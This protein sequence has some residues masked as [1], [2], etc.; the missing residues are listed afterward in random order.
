MSLAWCVI[1]DS[2]ISYHLRVTTFFGFSLVMTGKKLMFLST[3]WLTS[4]PTWN[5][6]LLMDTLILL[7]F[8]REIYMNCVR[9]SSK[10]LVFSYK[11]CLGMAL[12]LPPW[13]WPCPM[14]GWSL[15][16]NVVVVV[17]PLPLIAHVLS[18]LMIIINHST[19]IR[20]MTSSTRFTSKTFKLEVEAIG[21]DLLTHDLG[22]FT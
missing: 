1:G 22:K 8:E 2:R 14:L 21:Y 7:W 15:S 13:S 5:F 9:V 10:L 18:I 12:E 17:F 19:L 20:S 4:Y 11:F 6:K 16:L 3:N